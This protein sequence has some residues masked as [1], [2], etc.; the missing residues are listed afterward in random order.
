MPFWN[1]SQ[2]HTHRLVSMV[3]PKQVMF[4]MN[5]SITRAQGNNSCLGDKHK[6]IVSFSALNCQ[7]HFV[8]H[9]IKCNCRFSIRKQ[10]GSYSIPHSAL[11]IK[12]TIESQTDGKKEP[13]IVSDIIKSS[14]LRAQ[15]AQENFLLIPLGFLFYKWSYIAGLRSNFMLALTKWEEGNHYSSPLKVLKQ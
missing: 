4:T 14:C 7:L 12:I 13:L 3:T 9:N 2:R 1:C 5:M 11:C 8:P 15:R 6:R 10:M